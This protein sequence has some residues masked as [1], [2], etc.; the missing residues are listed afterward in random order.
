MAKGARS[1]KSSPRRAVSTT[2]DGLRL[3]KVGQW[4]LVFLVVVAVAATNT[5]NNGLYLVA[6]TMAA[7]LLV[8]HFLAARNV[9]RLRLKARGHGEVFAGQLVH[10]DVEVENRGWL[11]RWWLLV[12]L[13][14]GAAAEEGTKRLR[15]RPF[16]VSYLRR[17]ER[18]VGEVGVVFPRRGRQRVA[19]IHVWSLFPFGFY[20]K[21]LRHP[22]EQLRAGQHG[23]IPCRQ[24]LDHLQYAPGG[25]F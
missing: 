5:S 21:C 2:S 12:T 19:R 25:A 14:E 13:A 7:A 20:S 1:T 18:V 8:S 6:A 3:T 10:L 11:P 23:R 16:L 9:R 4:F 17:R 22:A 15:A 24:E